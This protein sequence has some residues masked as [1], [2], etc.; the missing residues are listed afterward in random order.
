MERPIQQ[1]V[2]QNSGYPFTGNCQKENENAAGFQARASDINDEIILRLNSHLD[3]FLIFTGE[4]TDTDP[5][6]TIITSPASQLITYSLKDAFTILVQ[7][8]HRHIDQ[9]LK[10]KREAEFPL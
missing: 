3:K 1:Y 7:H 4:C 10:V 6:K 5:D 8:L 2:W 9:A